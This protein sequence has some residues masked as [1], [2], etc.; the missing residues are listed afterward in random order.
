MKLFTLPSAFS[1]FSIQ[2]RILHRYDQLKF[3]DSFTIQNK[4]L[5]LW[6]YMRNNETLLFVS[7]WVWF[8]AFSH[9]RLFLSY[10]VRWLLQTLWWQRM[11]DRGDSIKT[12]HQIF[13]P[14]HL[15]MTNWSSASRAVLM[16]R[17]GTAATLFPTT[18]GSIC[19]KILTSPKKS[20]YLL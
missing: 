7:R 17:F 1:F 3:T 13:G 20:K 5:S 2:I 15:S 12:D 16:C 18:E 9:F 14:H 8:S 19:P 10:T 6:E 11:S 4:K